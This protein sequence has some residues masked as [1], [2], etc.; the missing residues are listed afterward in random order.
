M[1]IQD[2]PT[3]RCC[4]QGVEGSAHIL[5]ALWVLLH[6]NGIHC[7]VSVLL[8]LRTSAWAQSGSMGSEGKLASLGAALSH[9]QTG[10]GGKVTHTTC[11]SVGSA[12][13]PVL[14]CSPKL[15]YKSSLSCPQRWPAL[16][17]ATG[18]RPSPPCLAPLRCACWA[19]LSNRKDPWL[20]AGS[21]GTKPN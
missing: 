19:H 21:L 7:P 2:T 1:E 14:Q 18:Q 15:A 13:R 20:R 9:Q 17:C 6:S 11:F 16:Q 8:H 10:A 5:L 4:S 3:E 12:L